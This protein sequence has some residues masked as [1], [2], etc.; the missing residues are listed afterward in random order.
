[1]SKK[2][3]LIVE[4]EVRQ[5]QEIAVALEETGK[6]RVVLA[7]DGLQA[8]EQVENHRR[9]LGFAKNKITTII[10]D[11]KMPNMNGIQFLKELRKQEYFVT[12]M[13]V[14]IL[15]AYEDKEKWREVTNSYDGYVC[16]YCKKPVNIDE[17]LVALARIQGAESEVMI[18]QTQV[19]SYDK[20][21][22]LIDAPIEPI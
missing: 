18:Q 20:R 15:S 10:L 2:L 3:I 22:K 5:A 21:V 7:H 19:K 13:P 6:Y 12:K 4:D 16:E 11:L 8:L 9:W 1:M 17:V 14:I